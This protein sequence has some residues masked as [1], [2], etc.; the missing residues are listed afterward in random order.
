[1][2]ANMPQSHNGH[3]TPTPPLDPQAWRDDYVKTHGWR[4]SE[5]PYLHSLKW[6]DPESGIEHMTVLRADSLEALWQEV[7]QVSAL[8]KSVRVKHGAAQTAP[9]TSETSTLREGWCAKHQ[10]QMQQNHKDG[11]SWWSHKTAAGWCKGK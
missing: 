10:C 11:R 3:V 4:T 6:Q 9:Q 2:V 1:M 8:V 7:R 5:P